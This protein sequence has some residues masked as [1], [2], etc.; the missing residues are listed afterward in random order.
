M[1]RLASGPRKSQNNDVAGLA[2][3]DLVS[4]HNVMI[5]ASKEVGQLILGFLESEVKVSGSS[6]A[7]M[8]SRNYINYSQEVPRQMTGVHHAAYF[9]LAEV[10]MALLGN[11]HNSDVKD[12][13]GRT[14]LWLA[15]ESGHE[16][17]VKLLLE[18]GAELEAKDYG[19]RTSLWREAKDYGDQTSLWREAKD[20]GG[21]TPLWL[22]AEHGHT[23]VV[24]LLLEKGAE[25]EAKDHGRRTPLSRAAEEKHETMVK[26]LLEGLPAVL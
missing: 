9:G 21:R 11:G 20:Y 26:L 25:L 19:D 13:Y 1:M 14:P 18:K 15:A 4:E 3:Q 2:I 10:I 16:A 23:A 12:T 6:Q 8:V 22:V 5:V 7:M 17:V 24:K